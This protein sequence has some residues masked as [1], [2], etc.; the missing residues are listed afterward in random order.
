MCPPN[1]KEIPWNLAD[2]LALCDRTIHFDRD[3]DQ[4]WD[5]KYDGTRTKA[6]TKNMTGPGPKTRTRFVQGPRVGLGPG[7]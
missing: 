1:D 6:R 2:T 5:Q 3:R 4:G 7:P